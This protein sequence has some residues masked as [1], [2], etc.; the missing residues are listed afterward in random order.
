MKATNSKA[1][2][3]YYV[4]LPNLEYATRKSAHEYKYAVI[5]RYRKPEENWGDWYV[6][7]WSTKIE[8]ATKHADYLV[9]GCP[10]VKSHY[11]EIE[12]FVQ[13]VETFEQVESGVTRSGKDQPPTAEETG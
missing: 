4:S 9:K 12:A 3:E 5:A 13:P 1:K 2:T 7:R 6:A 11:Y 10:A 8:L